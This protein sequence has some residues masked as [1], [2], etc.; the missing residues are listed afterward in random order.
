MGIPRPPMM[1]P[2]FPIPPSSQPGGPI[3]MTLPPRMGLPHPGGPLLMTPP[4]T[5]LSSYG[6]NTNLTDNSPNQRN[7]NEKVNIIT[8][9]YSGTPL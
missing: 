2:N 6:S 7:D 4:T 9:I 8:N 1:I 5:D 3:L